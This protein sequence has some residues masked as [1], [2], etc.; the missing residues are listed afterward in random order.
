MNTP[1][2]PPPH[3]VTPAPTV[4]TAPE[5]VDHSA[6]I[7]RWLRN[8]ALAVVAAATIVTIGLGGV[9]WWLFGGDKSN[10]TAPMAVANL[11][12][13]V[14]APPVDIEPHWLECKKGD[15]L[16]RG[17]NGEQARYFERMPNLKTVTDVQRM[18]VSGLSPKLKCT[19]GP[20]DD[21]ELADES[22]EVTDKGKC[23]VD[24][25]VDATYTV[26]SLC[27]DEFDQLISA[28][29]LE[30]SLSPGWKP[31]PGLEGVQARCCPGD[32]VLNACQ[33]KHEHDGK[34]ASR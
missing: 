21:F 22:V 10:V 33:L 18:Y 11:D 15:F 34:V 3:I 8:L 25:V 30:E 29:D 20:S 24:G 26:R 12:E 31:V 16:S 2:P 17:P 13:E 7:A 23:V 14:A 1:N 6:T 9:A 28:N 32:G 27:V 19:A 5:L 4:A